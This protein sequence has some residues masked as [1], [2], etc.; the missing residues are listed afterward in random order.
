[1]CIG[2]MGIAPTVV[3][4]NVADE[5]RDACMTVALKLGGWNKENKS[6][7]GKSKRSRARLVPP[8]RA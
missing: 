2:G 7:D 6:N 5:L 3:N 8:Q 4:R 1:M